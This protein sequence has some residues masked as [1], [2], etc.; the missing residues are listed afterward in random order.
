VIGR[1]SSREI[2]R[3]RRAG[4]VVAEALALCERL[5]APGVTTAEMDAEVE[6]LIRKRNGV[7]LFKGYRGYPASICASVNNEVVHG[8]PGPKTLAEGDIISVDIGVQLDKYCGDAARTFPVGNVSAEAKKLMDVCRTGLERGIATLEPDM[9]L[10]KLSRAIQ[11][12]VEANGCSVVRQYTGHGIGREMHEDPQVPNFAALGMADPVL[13]EGVVLAIEPMVNAGKAAVEVLANG[14]TV[15][16]KD[17]SLS[18]HFEDTVAI[19]Q[20]GA[21]ILTRID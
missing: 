18:A 19:R 11:T 12:Y 3:M 8:I 2:E 10:S 9:R 13:P 1:K 16:T 21:D 15:V 14:W 17:R 4:A 7:P 20:D 5:V 6:A